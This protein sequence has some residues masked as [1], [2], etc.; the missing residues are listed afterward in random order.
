MPRYPMADSDVAALAAYLGTLSAGNSPGVDEKVIRF[1]T[2]VTEDVEPGEREAVLAV[3]NRFAEEI[4]RQTRLESERWDRGYTPESRLPTVFREWVIDDWVLSGSPETWNKQLESYYQQQ[5]IFAMLGGMGSGS[6]R[7]VSDFCEQQEIPCLFPGTDLPLARDGDF[8]TL[9]FSR[10][11]LLEADLI[12][13]HLSAQPAKRVLQVY[14]D[15]EVALAVTALRQSLE[16]AGTAEQTIAYDCREPLPRLTANDET[17]T[18]LWLRN[19]QLSDLPAGR[20][21]LSSTLLESE[22][23]ASASSSQGPVFMA[24]PFRLPGT[25]DSAVRR[26]ELWAKTREIDVTVPRQ[27]GQAFFASLVLK[28]ALKHMGRFF[29]RDYMLDI[30]DHAQNL[31]A[32]LPYYPRPTLGPGQRFLSKGGYVL[33]VTDGRIETADAEWLLPN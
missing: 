25:M 18:V 9:Y 6:W 30:L 23:S 20:I 10:G 1:A 12:A 32:Y 4:N 3:L 7:P 11:L 2:V 15:P 21:Y 26:F 24:H 5:P 14:C 31:V 29:V 19:D 17:A 16:Q 33:P 28:H 22:L 8:Y 13:T 27:Q